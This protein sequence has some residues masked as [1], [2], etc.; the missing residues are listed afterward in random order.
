MMSSLFRL[1]DFADVINRNKPKCHP[2]KRRKI[3]TLADWTYDGKKDLD[4]NIVH[5]FLRELDRLFPEEFTADPGLV[6]RIF[7][8][9]DR[10]LY[11]ST[12]KSFMKLGRLAT[13]E[14]RIISA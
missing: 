4:G 6:T 8:S 7:H 2:P 3:R 12:R 14:Y 13:L 9:E 1:S 5:F 11:L 10:Q